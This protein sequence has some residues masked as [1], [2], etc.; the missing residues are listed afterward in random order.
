M[1]NTN[2]GSVCFCLFK[3]SINKLNM[4]GTAKKIMSDILIHAFETQTRKTKTVLKFNT[5]RPN[6][7]NI[8]DV[9]PLD[10]IDGDI[11]RIATNFVNKTR[12]YKTKETER[13]TKRKSGT[14]KIDKLQPSV[15]TYITTKYPD[16]LEEPRY[17]YKDPITGTTRYYNIKLDGTIT[18]GKVT[19]KDFKIISEA[20]IADTVR[21]LFPDINIDDEF[22]ENT[23]V[24]LMEDVKFVE[25]YLE[26]MTMYYKKRQIDL[27][28]LETRFVVKEITD[29]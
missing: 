29:S 19:K 7:E 16:T 15:F 8:S 11:R 2:K 12:E 6:K 23:H 21:E 22:D 27:Q 28:T 17:P 20:A 5:V 25:K 24:A 3:I 14:E 10:K 9:I 13:K 1:H 26:T 18:P 4:E